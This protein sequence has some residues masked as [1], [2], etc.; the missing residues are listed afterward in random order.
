[1]AQE[2]RRELEAHSHDM[3]C[4]ALVPDERILGWM[5]RNTAHTGMWL[6]VLY[7]ISHYYAF[8]HLRA[9]GEAIALH[10]VGTEELWSLH[11]MRTL[12]LHLY[13]M[14]GGTHRLRY[15]GHEYTGLILD[16]LIY[17][18]GKLAV[19]EIAARLAE[20]VR[21]REQ[22]GESLAHAVMEAIL[23]LEKRKLVAFSRY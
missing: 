17:A 21:Y 15:F 6:Q 3:L 1:M 19:R 7:K 20:E 18:A 9:C 4:N 12:P 5:N 2:L 16:V 23:L 13:D 8:Y 14:G 22:G 10:S 11:P